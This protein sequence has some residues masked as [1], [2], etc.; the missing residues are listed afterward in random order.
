[1]SALDLLAPV[2]AVPP[3]D[4]SH[5]AVAELAEQFALDVAGVDE[6]QRSAYLAATGER[7]FAVVQQI[8]VH[9]LVP[10]V[11]AVLATLGSP[12]PEAGAISQG[13]TWSLLESFMGAVARLD[14][15]DPALTELVRLRGARLHDCAVCKSRRSLDAIDA[16]AT[17]ADF[18]AV[19]F[20]ATSTL[21]ARTK[22]ALGLVDAIVLTPYDVPAATVAAAR[23]ELSEA[24]IVEVVLDVM[25]N[26]ANKIAVALGADAATVTNGIELFRT[27]ADGNLAVV[28]GSEG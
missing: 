4:L 24:E 28:A 9:D 20:W 15:L 8:Y 3:P 18:A 7:A 2:A 17:D 14:S 11:R 1:M 27:D 13:D 16:G 25:R 26:A 22:A 12:T 23:A 5:P 6:T 21:D 19:D 10:R